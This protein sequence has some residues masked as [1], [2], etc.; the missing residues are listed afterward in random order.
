MSGIRELQTVWTG[1]AG[2][3]YYTTLRQTTVG[4]ISAQSFADNWAA[5]LTTVDIFFVNDLTA[6]IQDELR[7]IES[8]TGALIGTETITGASIPGVSTAEM[9]PRATQCL[10]QWQTPTIIGGRRIRGRSFLPGFNEGTNGATGAMDP[11]VRTAVQGAAETFRTAMET[12]GAPE[13]LVYSRTHFSG[14]PVES[15]TVWS[16]WAQLRSRRD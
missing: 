4:A 16:E 5:F 14:G 13:L 2:A 11:A 7:V 3:P 9:L 6:V 8:T 1:V 12:A 10:V 15:V